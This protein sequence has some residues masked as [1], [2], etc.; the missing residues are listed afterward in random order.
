[1]GTALNT[2]PCNVINTS[3]SQLHKYVILMSC[4]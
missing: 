1:M 2:C 3:T 4:G